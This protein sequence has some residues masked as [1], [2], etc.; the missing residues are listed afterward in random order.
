M[1]L[2]NRAPIQC[3]VLHLSTSATSLYRP[4][5]PY[6]IPPVGSPRRPI[7]LLNFEGSNTPALS[8]D[9]W[10]PAKPGGLARLNT[11]TNWAASL[12]VPATCQPDMSIP[13]LHL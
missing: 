11:A 5:H 10:F 8:E 2:R 1:W 12:W 3:T 9:R 7:R 13:A 6:S 4:P